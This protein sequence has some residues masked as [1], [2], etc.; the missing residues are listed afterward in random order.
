M[1]VSKYV[2]VNS[3][4][5]TDGTNGTPNHFFATR[6][7]RNNYFEVA[8]DELMEVLKRAQ[9]SFKSPDLMDEL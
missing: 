7:D 9:N 8:T 5:V 6:D 2:L 1:K 4:G 3:Y